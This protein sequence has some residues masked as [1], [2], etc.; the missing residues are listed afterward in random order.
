[1]MGGLKKTTELNTNRGEANR[2]SESIFN[3][4]F[5]SQFG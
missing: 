3:F 1:M 5:N 4:Q 2:G